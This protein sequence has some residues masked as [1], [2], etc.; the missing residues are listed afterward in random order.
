MAKRA[1]LS[2][3]SSLLLLPMLCVA[4]DPPRQ[5]SA[6]YRV[7]LRL[8]SEGLFAHEET[9]IEFRIEDTSRPDP[10]T[11]FTAV[12]RAT[13]QATIDMPAMPRMPQFTE[14][15]HAEPSPGDY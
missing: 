1:S 3:F 10:L 15:A 13:P 12:I 14:S 2:R 8:P 9:Q 6:N 7:T 4:A 11:G 5:T